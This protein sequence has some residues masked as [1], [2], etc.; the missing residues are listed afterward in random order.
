MASEDEP[1]GSVAA[2]GNPG[3]LRRIE[4]LA[5]V[6]GPLLPVAGPNL[7]QVLLHAKDCYALPLFRSA[8]STYENATLLVVSAR[9]EID[10]SD[11]ASPNSTSV[12]DAAA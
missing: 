5:A 9:S 11:H 12:S 10:R 6:I 2:R 7:T 8:S 1:L 4:L 3:C